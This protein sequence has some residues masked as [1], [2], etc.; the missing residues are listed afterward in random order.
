MGKYFSFAPRTIL[1]TLL[2]LLCVPGSLTCMGF[3]PSRFLMN[4]AN[5]RHQQEI[6]GRIKRE[7]KSLFPISSLPGHHWVHSIPQQRLSCQEAP[8]LCFLVT[9]PFLTLSYPFWQGRQQE[10]NSF[11]QLLSQDIVPS[12]AGFTSLCSHLCNWSL[13]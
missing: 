10:G 11:Q 1:C 13:Y 3:L 9:A 12:S 2:H 5:R 6:K 7:A 8:I 4:S